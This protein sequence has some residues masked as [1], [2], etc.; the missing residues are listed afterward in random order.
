LTARLPAS[1]NWRIGHFERKIPDGYMTT[2]QTGKNAFTDPT[3]GRLYEE[4]KRITQDPLW[5]RRRWQAIWLMNLH[6][7]SLAPA[8]ST[9]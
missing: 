5:S 7:S 3:I 4:L 6:A 1:A 8:A 9:P 2:V